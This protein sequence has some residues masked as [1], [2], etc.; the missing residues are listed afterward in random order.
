M[1]FKNPNRVLTNNP[2]ID[3]SQNILLG[4]NK[5]LQAKQVR[6]TY[7][8]LDTHADK[9]LNTEP[10]YENNEYI[11][12]S[13][14]YK[15]GLD[16][17]FKA[18]NM[19]QKTRNPS[20]TPDLSHFT[21]S[22][23]DFT[24]KEK[25]SFLHISKN[26]SAHKLDLRNINRQGTDVRRP[27]EIFD[28]IL[29][30]KADS[31][32]VIK[33]LLKSSNNLSSKLEYHNEIPYSKVK[34]TWSF[35]DVYRPKEALRSELAKSDP[36][37]SSDNRKILN[38]LSHSYHILNTYL[39][40]ENSIVD[41]KIRILKAKQ[42]NFNI[43]KNKHQQLQRFVQELECPYINRW[44]ETQALVRGDTSNPIIKRLKEQIINFER[45]SL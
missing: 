35:A 12:E 21:V 33:R 2:S 17:C 15:V 6:S 20:D 41:E 10:K 42:N 4:T 25:T 16:N 43:F 26:D 44:M 7:E 37:H 22:K 38:K 30:N 45:K 11:V 13:D 8:V 27:T 3:S 5:N 40:A 23:T 39:E 28:D 29:K 14:V 32:I 31:D 24:S 19:S 34:E 18:C 9:F 1:E 36:I